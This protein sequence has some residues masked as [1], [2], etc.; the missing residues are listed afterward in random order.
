MTGW[1]LGWMVSPRRYTEHLAVL[2]ECFNTSAPGFVQRAG[3]VALERGETLIADLRAQY[4]GGRKLVMD[5]LGS[6][7]R[8]ELSEP[9]GAFYAFPRLRGLANSLDFTQGLLEEED[10]GIAPGYTFGPGNDAY[11]RICFALS[12]ERLEEALKRIVRYI[13]RHDNE[14]GA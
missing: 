1:R 10:V 14:F 11:F 4:E 2:S 8:I 7:P 12:H 6:H 3:V 9:G 13:D 5:I